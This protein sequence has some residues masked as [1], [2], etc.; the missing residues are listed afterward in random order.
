MGFASHKPSYIFEN[1]PRGLEYD[2]V[3]AALNSAG[4]QLL[5]PYYAPMERLHLRLELGDLD[6]ISTISPKS[7]VPAFYSDAYIE[8]YN[9]AVALAARHLQL[10][11][12][13]DLANYSIS[14]YQRS[15]FLL[16]PEL[17]A[18]SEHH[19]RYREEA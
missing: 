9:V 5:P 11:S 10:S 3:V 15:G 7:G 16:G 14:S 13:A 1:Q 4:F 8:Y 6:A 19:P 12:L 18:M 17:R 2:I